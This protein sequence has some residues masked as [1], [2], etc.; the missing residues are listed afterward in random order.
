MQR[1]QQQKQLA[2]DFFKDQANGVGI[3]A[4]KNLKSG[5]NIELAIC[6]LQLNFQRNFRFLMEF[7]M[8]QS[9]SCELKRT[10]SKVIETRKE[11]H[12]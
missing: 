7:L 8:R 10:D 3:E 2:R 12:R 9:S 4:Q 11:R 5:N 1:R 6:R